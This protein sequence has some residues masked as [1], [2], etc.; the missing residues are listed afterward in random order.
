FRRGLGCS[1]KP[2]QLG[3]SFFKTIELDRFEQ[4]IDRVDFK[5]VQCESVERGREDNGR[6][7]WKLLEKFESRHSRHLN[8]EKNGIDGVSREKLNSLCGIDS[9]TDDL[10]AVCLAQ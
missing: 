1:V 6:L 4:I 7:F 5:G 3:Q 10:H 2:F 8:I 9:R